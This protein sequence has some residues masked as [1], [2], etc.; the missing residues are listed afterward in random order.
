MSSS[1]TTPTSSSLCCDRMRSV[2]AAPATELLDVPPVFGAPIIDTFVYGD[3]VTQGSV[4]KQ[5]GVYKNDHSDELMWWRNRIEAAVRRHRGR[6]ADLVE[7][8]VVATLVFFTARPGACPKWRC[9]PTERASS[10]S[11]R[12]YGG[13]LDK[14]ERALYDGLARTESNSQ[15]QKLNGKAVRTMRGAEVMA[16]DALVVAHQVQKVLAPVNE[17]TGVRVRLW[18]VDPAAERAGWMPVPVWPGWRYARYDEVT[19]L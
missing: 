15:T 17:E 18:V 16:D 2:T 10:R 3:P 7:L 14:L 13:D 12:R 1:A 6:D 5:F 11:G 9:Y 19:S 4:S 8:A